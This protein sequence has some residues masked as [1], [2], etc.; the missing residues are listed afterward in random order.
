MG[1]VLRNGVR[2]P[3]AVLAAVGVLENLQDKGGIAC[4]SY[5]AHR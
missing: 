5:T 1:V 2:H 3:R 4:G